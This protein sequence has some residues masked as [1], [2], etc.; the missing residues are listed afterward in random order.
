[1]SGNDLV[2][3]HAFTRLIPSG[4]FML[5]WLGFGRRQKAQLRG[6]AEEI[7]MKGLLSEVWI[8]W[9]GSSRNVDMSGTSKH[10]KQHFRLQGA[11]GGRTES[12]TKLHLQ[13]WQTGHLSDTLVKEDGHCQILVRKEGVEAKCFNPLSCCP[14]IS[15]PR[16]PRG[17]TQE[18][19]GAE[20]HRA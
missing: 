11:G 2:V 8:G 18:S 1:M 12:Q 5:L 9:R 7:L 15:C 20:V 14:Q 4:A 10:R 19:P 16:P 3:L 13:S 6:L 17:P